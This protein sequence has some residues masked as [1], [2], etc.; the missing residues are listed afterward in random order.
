MT[1]KLLFVGQERSKLAQERGV[2]WEDEAQCA[3]QLFR[4]LRAN[5]INPQK[6]SFVNLFT[7][8]SDGVKYVDKTVNDK[9]LNKI[10]RWKGQIIGMG[11]LVHKKLR[12]LK[13]E[14]HHIIHPSARGSIRLKEN[15]IR[16][17]S[18]KIGNL[19]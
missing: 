4:A 5:K 12:E 2:Y 8:E 18:E 11:S 19:A 9:G 16:H 17:I 7:D 13:V 14:H 10:C 3:N 15:Y 6:C 1:N